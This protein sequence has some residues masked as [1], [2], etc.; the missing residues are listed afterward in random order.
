M[1][2]RPKALRIT[3]CKKLRWGCRAP[4]AACNDPCRRSR[5]TVR[6]D[7]H[8]VMAG[9][10]QGGSLHG[11]SPDR[12]EPKEDCMMKLNAKMIAAGLVAVGLVLATIALVSADDEGSNI[13]KQDPSTAGSR[14]VCALQ[15]VARHAGPAASDCSTCTFACLS[16]APKDK[17]PHCAVFTSRF[18]DT[19]AAEA[20]VRFLRRQL[21]RT[22]PREMA[23]NEP[24]PNPAALAPPLSGGVYLPFPHTDR[25]GPVDGGVG[26]GE[27]AGLWRVDQH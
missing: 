2:A 8:D 25:C 9:G 22:V 27:P 5:T 20:A 17:I 4:A 14:G 3:P 7:L 24:S 26:A 21:R 11:A 12:R 1:R 13:E 16:G 19:H 6:R 18:L 15:D 10:L 23:C